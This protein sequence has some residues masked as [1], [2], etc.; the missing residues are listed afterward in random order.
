MGLR[1]F[2][3]RFKAAHPDAFE[4]VGSAQPDYLYVDANQ[5]LHACLHRGKPD[6]RNNRAGCGA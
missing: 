5:I 3:R 6:R 2:Y 1:G 4:P